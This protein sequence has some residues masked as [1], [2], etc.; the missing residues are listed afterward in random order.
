MPLSIKKRNDEHQRIQYTMTNK[1]LGYMTR[2]QCD[3][4]GLKML[5]Y[6]EQTNGFLVVD[7]SRMHSNPNSNL[8]FYEIDRKIQEMHQ[9]IHKNDVER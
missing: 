4:P 3:V 2:M 7:I 9:S 1:F 8:I 6:P 5:A